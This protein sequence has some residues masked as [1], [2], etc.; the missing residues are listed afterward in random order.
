M[1]CFL[2]F[3]SG[4]LIFIPALTAFSFLISTLEFSKLGFHVTYRLGYV[5]CLNSQNMCG[6]CATKVYSALGRVYRSLF[7][8]T[9]RVHYA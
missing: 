9:L 3:H 4:R 1:K 7:S 8:P 6:C 2:T 5:K